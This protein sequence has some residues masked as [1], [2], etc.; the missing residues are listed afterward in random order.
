MQKLLAKYCQLAGITKRISPHSLRHTFASFK[1]EAGFP[2]PAPTMAR[3]FFARHDPDL[4]PPDAQEREEGDGG[5]QFMT[6]FAKPRSPMKSRRSIHL[7]NIALLPA[8][9]PPFDHDWHELAKSLPAGGTLFVLP[10]NDV[11]IRRSMIAIAAHLRR[12]GHRFSASHHRTLFA[13]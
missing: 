9:A 7:D 13:P 2:V 5:D 11:P 6:P 3:A 12:C 4:R 1:A 8:S 10:E